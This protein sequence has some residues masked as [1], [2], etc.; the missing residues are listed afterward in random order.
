MESPTITPLSPPHLPFLL[1][2]QVAAPQGVLAARLATAG[3]P[4][5]DV[6]LQLSP[7]AHQLDARVPQLSSPVR[8][9]AAGQCPRRPPLQQAKGTGCVVQICKYE[10]IG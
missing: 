10:L 5:G 1:A 8:W 2:L 3:H 6:A 7:A 4:I 9:Q